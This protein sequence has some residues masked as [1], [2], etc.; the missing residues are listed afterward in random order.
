VRIRKG[1]LEDSGKTV[2]KGTILVGFVVEITVVSNNVV[3]P[4]VK[5]VI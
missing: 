1:S 3:P 5:N 4:L 2:R